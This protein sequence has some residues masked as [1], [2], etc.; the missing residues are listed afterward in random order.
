M[1][2]YITLLLALALMLGLCSCTIKL[3]TSS[4]PN[5]EEPKKE[6]SEIIEPVEEKE[7]TLEELMEEKSTI[8]LLKADV[9]DAKFIAPALDKNTQTWGYIDLKGNWVIKPQFKYAASFSGK[10]ASVVDIYG[11]YIFI[12]SSGA[13]I[14]G[15][16]KKAPVI[17]NETVFSDGVANVSV[18][19]SFS[20][21]MTYVDAAGNIAVDLS[22]VPR[23]QNTNYKNIKYVELATPFRNGKAVVIRNTNATLAAANSK[24]AERAYIIDKTGKVLAALPNGLDPSIWGF[25][26]NMMITVRTAKGLYGLANEAGKVVIH[27][28]YKRIQHCEGDLYLACDQNG[29]WGYLDKDGNTIIEFIYS[30]AMP[31]SEGLAAVYDG[32]AWGFISQSGEP[33][34]P[35]VYDSVQALKSPANGD[36]ESRGAF[37]CGIAVVQAGRFWGVIDEFGNIRFA[38]EAKDCPVLNV[39]N[40]YLTFSYSDGCGVITTDAKLV[41]IPI[42]DNIG[43]FR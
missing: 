8:E 34:I 22:S 19:I 6:E 20:Q 35:F 23:S 28:D 29:F 33:V 1:K 21:K 15:A 38:A 27:A 14:F 10:Y 4:L 5:G 13:N 26:E 30:N 42:Y 25:D 43:E 37:S 2:R 40:G 7:P 39:S 3:S 32:N 18:D 31:F 36:I 11:D 16:N 12:N 24:S 41:L 9:G 17:K